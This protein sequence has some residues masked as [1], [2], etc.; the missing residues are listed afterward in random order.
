MLVMA[1][2]D[3][4]GEAASDADANLIGGVSMFLMLDREIVGEAGGVDEAVLI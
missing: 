1:D 3:S 4:F 2:R